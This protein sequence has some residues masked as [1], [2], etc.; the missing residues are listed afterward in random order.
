LAKKFEILRI[1]GEDYRHRGLPTAPPPLSTEEVVRS[2]RTPRGPLDSFP[3]LLAHLGEVHPSRYGAMLEGLS[4]VCLT[5]VDVLSDQADALRLVVLVDRMYDRDI[6]LAASGAPVD[7][8]FP[9]DMLSGGY[10]KK[11][12]RAISRLTAGQTAVAD[13]E[14]TLA[15]SAETLGR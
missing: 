6:A 2:R 12:R 11:Y 15:V 9:V 5:D 10:R 7:S 14:A 8:L 1:D 3:D 13:G 4:T